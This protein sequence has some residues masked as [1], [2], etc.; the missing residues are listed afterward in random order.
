MPAEPVQHNTRVH[1][2]AE[3]GDDIEVH[4]EC[5]VDRLNGEMERDNFRVFIN[6][7]PSPGFDVMMKALNISFAELISEAPRRRNV[8]DDAPDFGL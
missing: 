2:I 3:Y 5:E 6:G 4:Y 8:H 1:R 7:L